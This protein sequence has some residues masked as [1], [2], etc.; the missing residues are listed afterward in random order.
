MPHLLSG[1]VAGALKHSGMRKW[2][3]AR[4]MRKW[5]GDRHSQGWVVP[6]ECAEAEEILAPMA[7]VEVLYAPSV[8]PSILCVVLACVISILYLKIKAISPN[9]HCNLENKIPLSDKEMENKKLAATSH[10]SILMPS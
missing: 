5:D 4:S 7:F 9:K 2:D 10:V 1:T 6:V 3:G 8:T